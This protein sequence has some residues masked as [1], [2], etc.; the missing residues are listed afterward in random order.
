MTITRGE[1][2]ASGAYIQIDLALDDLTAERLGQIMPRCD[3]PV[4]LPHLN[5][6]MGAYG[7][8]T[9]IRI[10]CFLAQIAHESA[11]C[12]R[13]EENLSYTS[14]RILQVWP[15]RFFDLADAR[16]C[17]RQPEILANRV[18][19]NRLGNGPAITGDGYRY[20][21]GGLIQLT[22]M[23]NY[24]AAEDATGWPLVAHPDKLRRAGQPA[25]DTAAWFF[26]SKGCNTAADR[27]PGE[28]EAW[29]DITRRINGGTHGLADRS[30]Y[31][32][33]AR[34]VLSC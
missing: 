33:T 19:G 13:L 28:P 6:A 4:W 15:T 27:L 11:E 18:Y 23:T 30:R 5:K 2:F 1:S 21:G 29:T 25:A 20:R 12:T 22:G 8:V 14:E 24:T 32:D 3:V 7:I 34:E 10:A 9:P 31:L 16:S 17:E 26:S